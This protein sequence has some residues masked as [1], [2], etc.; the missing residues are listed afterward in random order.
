MSKS[1]KL[2]DN[3]FIDSTGIVHNK[4]LLS[5][6]II[7]DS[8]S[9]DNGS[10]VRFEDGT[11]I[12]WGERSLGSVVCGVSW[13]YAYETET[14][15]NLGSYPQAFIER[16]ILSL[17]QI[18][19][20][21]CYPEVINNSTNTSLGETWFWRPQKTTCGGVIYGYIAIGKWK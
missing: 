2:K 9:N 12:C 10:W 6:K 14:S 11:M 13:G 3:N 1:I 15:I 20:G 18:T 16:P 19:G 8:G 17:N 21:T 7:H 5:T 4:E